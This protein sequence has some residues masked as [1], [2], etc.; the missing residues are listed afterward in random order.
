MNVGAITRLGAV[1]E[2]GQPGRYA[3]VRAM[4]RHMEAVGLDSIWFFDHLLYRRPGRPSDGTWEC[5]TVL[6]ALA[7][8]TTRVQL[9]T[10]VVCTPFRNPA[11][12]AKMA[13][14]LD[15]VSDGR[16]PPGVGAGWHQPEFDAFG[17]PFDHRVGRFEEALQI[18]GP[19][20]RTGR[21][22]F[23]GR[24]YQAPDC[25]ILPSGP[26]AGGP[27][28][29]IAGVGPRMLRLTAQHADLWNTAWH[30]DPRSVV[31]HLATMRDACID[32]GRDPTT[33]AMTVCVTLAVP[34]LV[35]NMPPNALSGTTDEI[36]HA[37][38]GYADLGVTDVI[39]NVHPYTAEAV[40]RF[41]DAVHLFRQPA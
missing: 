31:P 34:E 5:W 20:L 11:L 2:G 38:R 21:V 9:G 40:A 3:D 8:A 1:S 4:A 14:T 23:R 15:E 16:F 35:D 28:L 18:V 22:D 13:V 19:L 25:E 29:L 17:V 6:S 36:A 12:L 41:A 26:R 37:L 10:I 24:Y 7:E 33:L 32:A 27:P 39:A 30:T